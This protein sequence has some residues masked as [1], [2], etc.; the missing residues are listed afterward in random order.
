MWKKNL[1]I[2]PLPLYNT[3]GNV[4]TCTHYMANSGNIGHKYNTKKANI[5]CDRPECSVNV[6]DEKKNGVMRKARRTS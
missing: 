4:E 2:I 1:T 6:R 3:H 5:E